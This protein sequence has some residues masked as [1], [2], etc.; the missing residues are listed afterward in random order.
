MSLGWWI[1][2]LLLLHQFGKDA[3]V[4][5][6]P[7]KTSACYGGHP[8]NFFIAVSVWCPKNWVLWALQQQDAR[9]GEGNWSIALESIISYKRRD[10][11]L[12]SWS[13]VYWQRKWCMA[14]VAVINC[15]KTMELLSKFRLMMMMTWH[16][17]DKNASNGKFP[18]QGFLASRY[19]TNFAF[20]AA[21]VEVHFLFSKKN[22]SFNIPLLTVN[23]FLMINV[24]TVSEYQISNIPITLPWTNVCSIKDVGQNQYIIDNGQNWQKNILSF[25]RTGPR[26]VQN[27]LNPHCLFSIGWV[28]NK[29]QV[30]LTGK[31]PSPMED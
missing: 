15:A 25:G 3:S 20:H 21:D 26:S 16:Q 8:E 5:Y 18:Q 27:N 23:S 14:Q 2:P 17:S 12:W 24:R 31:A 29:E 7:L 10:N 30:N 19:I 4:V 28:S 1:F 13:N 9:I 11:A 22:P 6:F